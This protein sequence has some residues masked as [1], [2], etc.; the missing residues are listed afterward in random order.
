MAS[1]S[2]EPSPKRQRGQ[3]YVKRHDDDDDP[4][5]ST[6]EDVEDDKETRLVEYQPPAASMHTTPDDII[7][8]AIIILLEYNDRSN[9]ATT[10]R[11]FAEM[12]RSE[13]VCRFVFRI[14]YAEGRLVSYEEARASLWMMHQTNREEPYIEET[15]DEFI[16]DIAVRTSENE[17]PAHG[18]W[19]LLLRKFA[20]QLRLLSERIYIYSVRMDEETRYGGYV[21][22]LLKIGDDMVF[23]YV[24]RKRLL[25]DDI[26]WFRQP[27]PEYTHNE[28]IL[29]SALRMLEVLSER[30]PRE[31]SAEVMGHPEMA[32]VNPNDHYWRQYHN[33]MKLVRSL[34]DRVADFP[35]TERF[36]RHR[37]TAFTIIRQTINTRLDA[38]E[39][40]TQLRKRHTDVPYGFLVE[41]KE[42]VQLRN[43]VPTTGFPS[44]EE[45]EI[46]MA[47][48]DKLCEPSEECQM[49]VT[50]VEGWYKEMDAQ[51]AAAA[52]AAARANPV[53]RHYHLL[54][55]RWR[56][57]PY[58]YAMQQVLGRVVNLPDTDANNRNRQN[59]FRIIM[60]TLNTQLD[61]LEQDNEPHLHRRGL[62][63]LYGFLTQLK[64]IVERQNVTGLPPVEEI[65]E[66]MTRIDKFMESVEEWKQLRASGV[67]HG[68]H[69]GGGGDRSKIETMFTAEE[70]DYIHMFLIVSL[71]DDNVEQLERLTTAFL[72]VV[73]NH[74]SRS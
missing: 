4:L 32:T 72:G 48:I 19:W 28:T 12:I 40:V 2:Y 71:E 38:L 15:E 44:V 51:D 14:N 25:G 26:N 73:Q 47:R 63:F 62:H 33:M 50:T 17:G 74:Y 59:V 56:S 70:V 49:L 65:E 16:A 43:M 23:D 66:S 67:V 11:R 37:T 29:Y 6:D 35:A 34:L 18:R 3:W 57:T 7:E 30:L 10:A 58:Y 46:I 54:S 1:S 5:S 24:V 36:N 27:H 64:R 42:V 53:D 8:T 31:F 39:G 60:Q 21:N 55:G 69:S 61:K 13:K 52:A 9:L 41:M 68:G 20:L 22:E 45:I